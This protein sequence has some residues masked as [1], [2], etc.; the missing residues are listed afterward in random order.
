MV[1]AYGASLPVEDENVKFAAAPKLPP[2]LNCI[3]VSA[4]ATVLPAPPSSVAQT[5][6]PFA[7]VVRV[8]PLA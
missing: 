6:L 1:E 3:W 5:T 8:P 7:S 2:L 4:P